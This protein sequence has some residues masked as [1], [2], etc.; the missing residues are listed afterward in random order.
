M[1]SF[2]ISVSL[3]LFT[4]LFHD[5]TCNELFA[6]L[7]KSVV[8]THYQLTLEPDLVNL[9]F[10]GEEVI[11][12][13]ILEGTGTIVLNSLDLSITE[14]SYQ[15]D[16][17]AD[18]IKA[19]YINIDRY[20]E[21]ATFVF[22]YN[23]KTG[24]GRVKILF[25]GN[26]TERLAG[27]Y[28][29]KYPHVEGQPD[30]YSAVTHFEPTN[31][32]RAFPC[33]DEPAIKATFQINLVAP[34]DQVTLSNMP[35]VKQEIRSDDKKVVRFDVTPKMSTYLVA[36]IV[37]EYD[38][39][40]SSLVLENNRSIEVRVYTPPGKKEQGQFALDVAVKVLDF[41]TK[42]F[43]IEYPLPKMDL[44]ALTDF[45]AGAMENWGL[46]TYRETALLYDP[47]T[48]SAASK[49][50][51]ASVVAH[52]L[53]HQWFGNLVTMEWWTHL[54]LNEG[55][56]TFMADFSTDHLFPEYKMWEQ[57]VSDTLGVA[58][59]LDALNNS[60][61]IEVLVN[62]PAEAREVFDDIS[63]K[64]G[65]SILRMLLKYLGE[66]NFR[67]GLKI[68]LNRFKYSNTQ[69]DDLWKALE[70]ASGK[71]VGEVMTT[72]TKQKG[73]PVV[74][75]SQSVDVN[76][77]VV[78]NLRQQ[79]FTLNPEAD[80]KSIW[81]IPMTVTTKDSPSD[82]V[83]NTLMTNKTMNLVLEGTSET[84]WM[85]LN[86][87]FVG[88][89][90]VQY[91]TELTKKLLPAIESKSLPPL[92]RLNVQ[93]DLFALVQASISSTV[94]L[95]NLLESFK[96]EEAYPVWK[97]ISNSLGKMSQLFSNT[98]YH[99]EYLAWGS[100][101][102]RPIYSKLGWESQKSDSH[103]DT[104]LRSVILAR[105]ASFND[106][107]ISVKAK[108]LFDLHVSASSVLSPDIRPAVYSAVARNADE[109]TLE[110]LLQLYRKAD[111]QEERMRLANSMAAV[112][113]TSMLKRVL[114]FA[115]SDEVRTQDAYIVVCNV[116]ANKHGRDLAWRFFQD[117]GAKFSSIYGSGSPIAR[118][119]ECVTEYYA[120]EEKA[121][122]VEAFFASNSFPGSERTLQ[123]SLENIRLN[124]RW[125]ARDGESVRQYLKKSN[126]A[127]PETTPSRAFSLQT[128]GILTVFVWV[129][130]QM[131]FTLYL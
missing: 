38:Y 43:E 91:S 21:R 123:Q 60:H 96:D 83:L 3:L 58:L 34:Q 10:K 82:P 19:N 55:F 26:L 69:T 124:A 130:Y 114:D 73:F 48:T 86:Q 97:S 70:V 36:F 11:N 33:W 98:D 46:V 101:L 8:P 85:K 67:Q 94:D 90:R 30:K 22:P 44:I 54:W 23:L 68:Y 93:D 131:I 27:F 71:P 95:L 37:G 40:Q 5:A 121:L 103:E 52:E 100:R 57:F 115:M 112:P 116:A 122:E 113:D 12:V 51:I 88:V 78:L 35:V 7:P 50:Y 41:Y 105:L 61:P 16:D 108:K 87:D 2:V 75:V 119:V 72:W 74:Y 15:S 42:Y 4:Q 81:M 53:A 59:Q 18:S 110:T 39:L 127:H 28:R 76:N 20:N 128:S 49:Q 125:L 118:L 129:L 77:S 84:S 31:A 32:R 126:E 47:Q 24:T 104:L 80:D 25:S 64:K 66:E 120:S 6:R 14:A 63:Y 109:K 111:T 17:G 1:N 99:D 89:Y 9:T 106:P 62:D 79:K 29:A 117:N 107:S 45:E 13:N 65:G 102:L 92:D 56:A